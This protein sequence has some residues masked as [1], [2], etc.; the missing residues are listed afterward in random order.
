MYSVYKS[1]GNADE[2]MAKSAAILSF[3]FVRRESASG[4]RR[5]W[6]GVAQ[7]RGMDSSM[8]VRVGRTVSQG[9]LRGE[10]SKAR[11]VARRPLTEMV[12]RDLE[13]LFGTVNSVLRVGV[14]AVKISSPA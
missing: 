8:S 9:A 5:D 12:L 7:R 14:A 11:S 13:M 3:C 10:V 4:G 6:R 1:S 2:T